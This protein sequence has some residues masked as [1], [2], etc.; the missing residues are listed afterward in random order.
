MVPKRGFTLV[1]ML[2]ALVIGA[3]VALTGLWAL[4]NVTRSREAVYYYW[5]TSGQARYVLNRIRNDLANFYRSDEPGRMQFIGIQGSATT[6]GTSGR[7]IFDATGQT[8]PYPA[9]SYAAGSYS[10]G[11]ASYRKPRRPDICR[12][13]YWSNYDRDVERRVLYRRCS[14]PETT[15]TGAH[16]RYSETLRLASNVT[17]LTFSYFDG[18]RWLNG[19]NHRKNPP[20]MVRIRLG[21]SDPQGRYGPVVVSQGVSLEP[22]PQSTNENRQKQPMTTGTTPGG[23]TGGSAGQRSKAE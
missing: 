2:A 13:E 15:A 21:I 17:T 8:T 7:I 1:E 19:W 4:R 14:S 6:R 11:S 22:L 23:E 10:T 9:K 20:K 3:L 16:G 12:I 5:E 18:Q